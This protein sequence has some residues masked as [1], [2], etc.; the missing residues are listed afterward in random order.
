MKPIDTIE[1]TIRDNLRRGSPAFLGTPLDSD[2]YRSSVSSLLDARL[3]TIAGA[4]S[5]READAIYVDG[6][7]SLVGLPGA[8]FTGGYEWLDGHCYFRLQATLAAFEAFGVLGKFG[9]PLEKAAVTWSYGPLAADGG[10]SPVTATSSLR[11]R[12]D[13]KLGSLVVPIEVQPPAADGLWRLGGAF[14]EIPLQKGLASILKWLG[15]GDLASILPRPLASLGGFSLSK[16]SLAF[17]SAKASVESIGVGITTS[18]PWP[19]WGRQAVLKDLLL[20]FG[21]SRSQV[22]GSP[23]VQASVYASMELG[24]QTVDVRL[25][26]DSASGILELVVMAG[27]DFR[28]PSLDDLARFA[29]YPKLFQALPASVARIN[30]VVLREFALEI[31]SKSLGLSL[32]RAELVCPEPL[33]LAK[34]ASLDNVNLFLE[35]TP[36]TASPLTA[37]L[38]ALL[39]VGDKAIPL[40]GRL[41]KGL[42]FTGAVSRLSFAELAKKFVPGLPPGLPELELRDVEIHLSSAGA[43]R[44]TSGVKLDFHA[45]TAKLKIPLPHGLA[46]VELSVLDL[47]VDLAAGTWSLLLKTPMAV[48]L[49]SGGASHLDVSGIE[50]SLE[51]DGKTTL[52]CRFKLGGRIS[53]T[54][55]VRIESDGLTCSWRTGT[56]GQWKVEGAVTVTVGKTRLPF[57]PVIDIEGEHCRFG[58]RYG[59][60]LQL[61]SLPGAKTTVT[62]DELAVGVEKDGENGR[63]KWSLSGKVRF[64]IADKLI[65]ADGA[66]KLANGQLEITASVSNP[67]KIALPLK[68]GPTIDLDLKPLRL[69]LGRGDGQGP[70]IEAGAS[71][72]LRGVPAPANT[73]FPPKPMTGTLKVDAK[74][75]AIRFDPPGEP[76][77]DVTFAKGTP[78]QV[79]FPKIEIKAFFLDRVRIEKKSSWRLGAELHVTRLNQLNKLFGGADLF[80]ESVDLLVSLGSGLSVTPRTSPFKAV[81]LRTLA[82]QTV[83]TEWVK[84]LDIGTF[85]F[86]VPEFAFDFAGGRWHAAGGIDTKGELAIPLEPVKWLFGKCGFPSGLLKA[87]PGSVPLVELDLG[88]PDFYKQLLRMIGKADATA[89]AVFK[90]L[91]ALLQQGIKR[92]PGNLE[93]YLHLRI[94]RGFNFDIGVEPTGGFSFAV[95]AQGDEPIKVLSPS[96]VGVPPLPGLLGITLYRVSFGLS[97]GGAVGVFKADGWLDQF[98]GLS[99]VYALA[100]DAG[101]SLANRFIL[102]DT[103]VLIPM[104]APL[105]IPLF[106]RQLGWEYRNVLGLGMQLHASF[107]DPQPSLSDWIALLGDLVKFFTDMGYYLHEPDHLPHGMNLEFTLEPT[108]LSLPAYLGGA[109]LGSTRNL[110][111]LSVS[112][113][114]ARALD[115]AK[116]G[117]LGWLIQSI[118]LNYTQSG[119]TVWIRVGR[120]QIAFGPLQFAVGWCITTED[121]FR[122]QVLRDPQAVEAL[123]VANAERMLECLPARYGGEAY[124]K[125]F[126]VMLMGE[127]AARTALADIFAFRCQFGMALL[128]P[129]DFA[130]AVRLVA[131]FGPP[132]ALALGIEGRIQVE[133]GKEAGAEIIAVGGKIYLVVL[134]KELAL[135]GRLVVVP[136]RSFEADIGLTLTPQLRIVGTLRVD[137]KGVAIVGDVA[138]TGIGNSSGRFRT[139]TVFSKQGV[140]FEPFDL[141]LG[142]FGCRAS[143][144]LPGKSKGSAFTLGV[145]VSL[146]KSF[147]EDFKA[148]LKATANEIVTDEF[149]K[150]YGDLQSFIAAQNGFEASLRGLQDWLPGLCQGIINGI[151]NATT[152]RSVHAY[153]DRWAGG[154]LIKKG[155][156]AV[157]KATAPEKTAQASA[158]PWIRKLTAVRD[159]ASRPLD[160]SYQARL[161]DT[162]R[163]L[164][165]ANEVIVRIASIGKFPGIQV[166]RHAPVLNGQ[167]IGWIDAAIRAIGE[168]PKVSSARVGADNI[169]KRF[170]RKQQIMAQVRQGIDQGIDSAVP[171]LESV[172]FEYSA[173][174]LS[175]T[176]VTLSAVFTFNQKRIQRSVAVDLT[177][178]DRTAKA[179][180]KAFAD[181][182]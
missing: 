141:R 21:F 144:Q 33:A 171:G 124:D 75:L 54:P 2:V 77:I 39:M 41:E 30:N 148:G 42:E 149:N 94:P 59:K 15:V 132:G 95:S 150:A 34:G 140:L 165:R 134:G 29:G 12:G 166:Y 13:L 120:E 87:M 160:Q 127:I 161:Q 158:A 157:A 173:G 35:I 88:S 14:D 66:L 175:L 8:P 91:A 181:A 154:N 168:L 45:L 177:R 111:S 27:E 153:M 162:L 79:R 37:S 6:Q 83:W 116:S 1:A 74:G 89:Q 5:R 53:V 103:T 64:D 58:L 50:L 130:T 99:L 19:L 122:N 61:A 170:P 104:S 25:G 93:D 163:D 128:G 10:S 90:K 24:G 69:I 156:V 48:Q 121:E 101:K 78:M 167:Q 96:M 143:L 176:S 70:A 65:R 4:S 20:S 86:R 113:T 118:P 55:D 110:P 146:P 32:L 178:P 92:V 179:L 18:A 51:H 38:S 76:S 174:P 40:A 26:R 117:N 67:P 139:R 123:A 182:F 62:A 7:A 142:G 169:L 73:L 11:F 56:R 159:A 43:L 151:N 135:S 98:D 108:A 164:R 44:F 119:K 97:A 81:R 22:D 52:A 80:E 147:S 172:G 180:A 152:R 155:V 49:P 28:L 23:S 126:V 112:N 63:Y 84:I 71:I 106:Y 107:P 82:D 137:A 138:W 57:V 68:P 3:L 129:R 125:G 72:T 133:P 60:P 16:L 109:T 114:L 100:T 31:D 136:G 105:P 36:G 46:R 145:G 85:S 131:T 17:N 9:S 102:R 115:S 47:Q